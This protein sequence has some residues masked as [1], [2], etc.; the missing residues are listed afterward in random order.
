[1]Y[2]TPSSA[3]HRAAVGQDETEYGQTKPPAAVQPAVRSFTALCSEKLR[4][5][6]EFYCL[7]TGVL[8]HKLQILLICS[9]IGQFK[10]FMLLN[11]TECF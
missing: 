5:L 8:S 7:S 1:M 4:S 6:H 10:V 2:I 3:E 11:I 9:K